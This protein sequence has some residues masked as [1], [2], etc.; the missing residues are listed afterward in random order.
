MW[1]S[2]YNFKF[3]LQE[4]VR[5]WVEVGQSVEPHPH[6]DLPPK[7][8]REQFPLPRREGAGG[9]WKNQKIEAHSGPSRLYS[10]LHTK[11]RRTKNNLKVRE[12]DKGLVFLRGAKT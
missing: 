4:G 2:E 11:C 5:G 7:R 6:P 1:I 9:G 10:K 3:P 12:G 8:G